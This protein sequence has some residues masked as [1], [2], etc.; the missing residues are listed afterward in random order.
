ML[1]YHIKTEPRSQ[2]DL[3]KVLPCLEPVEKDGVVVF[4]PV[5][6]KYK[7]LKASSYSITSQLES[8]ARLAASPSLDFNSINENDRLSHDLSQFIDFKN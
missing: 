2:I 5:E 7:G 8:G 4:V 1:N 6:D 3:S